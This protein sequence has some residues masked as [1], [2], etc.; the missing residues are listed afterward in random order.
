LVFFVFFVA[1]RLGAFRGVLPS[2]PPPLRLPVAGTRDHHFCRLD[3]RQCVI[4]PAQLERSY[5]ISGDDGRQRLIA[6]T[7]AYLCEQAIDADFIDE[8]VQAIPRAQAVKGLVGLSDTS[9]TATLRLLAGEQAID[10]VVGD[11]MVSALG[12]DGPHVAGMHP[13]LQRRI[14]DAELLRRSSHGVK[15]HSTPF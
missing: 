15:R 3:D 4:P 6:D 10:F 13:P 14:G 12:A 7:H 2:R 9:S 11:A 8:P 5:G 1:G